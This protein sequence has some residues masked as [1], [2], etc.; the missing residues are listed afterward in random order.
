MF[1]APPNI[2]LLPLVRFV[3]A[4][5]FPPPKTEDELKVAKPDV[6]VVVVVAVS[7]KVEPIVVPTAGTVDARAELFTPNAVLV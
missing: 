3:G 5:K 6:G 2:L 1:V 7:A 4:L